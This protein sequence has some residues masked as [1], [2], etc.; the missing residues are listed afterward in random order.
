MSALIEDPT[1]RALSALHDNQFILQ[2]GNASAQQQGQAY[3]PDFTESLKINTATSESGTTGLKYRWETYWDK[4]ASTFSDQSDY[5]YGSID[6]AKTAGMAVAAS[7]SGIVLVLVRSEEGKVVGSFDV[8]GETTN[9]E[10]GKEQQKQG[11]GEAAEQGKGEGIKPTLF[12]RYRLIGYRWTWTDKESTD[13]RNWKGEGSYFDLE[14]SP[15]SYGSAEDALEAGKTVGQTNLDVIQVYGEPNNKI[16]PSKFHQYNDRMTTA[17]NAAAKESGAAYEEY[18]QPGEYK[19]PEESFPGTDTAVKPG[20][21]DTLKNL[22]FKVKLGIA[23]VVAGTIGGA[24]LLL[25]K[26]K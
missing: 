16:F 26:K 17:T 18:T 8:S 2:T 9:I 6:A 10:P 15:Y 12:Y 19:F 5:T 14:S 11:E 3:S 7:R 22:D 13:P 25:R 24:A 20:L 23:A 4:S 1:I 21:L